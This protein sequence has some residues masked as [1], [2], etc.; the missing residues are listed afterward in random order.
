MWKP[1]PPFR[2][3]ICHSV[4]EI[5][6]FVRF[7]WNSVHD[8][9]TKSVSSMRAFREKR[10]RYSCTL[11]KGVSEFV[12]ASTIFLDGFVWTGY[13]KSSPKWQINHNRR[14]GSHNAY[15]SINWKQKIARNF[16][17]LPSIW[18]TFGTEYIR[19]KFLGDCK[20]Y[21][22]QFIWKNT[23]FGAGGTLPWGA[24]TLF[25]LCRLSNVMTES[26]CGWSNQLNVLCSDVVLA[27]I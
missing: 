19:N 21:K 17:I 24:S 12:L 14:S 16:Y 20:F 13:R 27:W 4:S 26:W 6:P 1:H 15:Q 9:Y 25:H 11:L 3:S 7:S 22:N 2:L 8:F 18:T 10:H 5:N 23:F